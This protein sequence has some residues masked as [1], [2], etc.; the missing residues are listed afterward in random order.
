MLI[1]LDKGGQFI[2]F[3]ATIGKT[4]NLRIKSGMG[5]ETK[6][7]LL[8][9]QCI[10]LNH[11]LK[12]IRK[13]KKFKHKIYY[14]A[15]KELQQ[16]D[17]LHLHI[18]FNIHLNNLLNFIE[19]IYWYKKQKFKNAYQIGRTHFELSNAYRKQIESVYRLQEVRDKKNHKRIMYVL[20]YIE[21][22]AFISGECTF[23]EF[24]GIKNL[25]EKY[26]EKFTKYIQKTILSQINV[27]NLK[28]GVIKNWNEHN[29]KTILQQATNKKFR[30]Q[31]KLIR[32]ICKKVYT[33]SRFPVSFKLYQQNYT[34]LKKLSHRYIS[35]YNVIKDFTDKKLLIVDSEFVVPEVSYA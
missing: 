27:K 31:I 25:K 6:I 14:L 30:T 8:K 26:N 33:Y 18:S 11:F 12:K 1:G 15:T 32:E 13:S 21:T 2:L 34:K 3:T 7:K 16:N 35:F 29:V 20:P 28:L 24:I 10:A 4:D 22:R 17:N 5:M 23:I 19:F 9:K